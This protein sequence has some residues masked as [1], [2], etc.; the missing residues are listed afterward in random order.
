MVSLGGG[1]NYTMRVDL[2]AAMTKMPKM[3][4]WSGAW[5]GPLL[6]SFFVGY[7]IGNPFG[8]LA[9]Q[10][11]GGKRV[12]GRPRHTTHR[13]NLNLPHKIELDD[14]SDSILSN[15]KTGELRRIFALICYDSAFGQTID[16]VVL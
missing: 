2:S 16:Y 3:Y 6:A 7:M 9:A 11:F 12:P 10:R 15:D 8:A 1:I 13:S 5:D 14:D 4:N